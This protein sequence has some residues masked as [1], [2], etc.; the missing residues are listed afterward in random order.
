MKIAQIAKLIL[1]I[2]VIT[3]IACG[4]GDGNTLT[5]TRDGKI[6][7]IVKIGEQVWMA[8]NLNYA[9]EGSECYDKDQVNC[10]KYGRLYNWETAMKACPGGWHLPNAKEWKTLVDSAGGDKTAGKILKASKGWNDKGNG[11]DAFGFSALPGGY[12]GIG[13][14]YEGFF[15]AGEGGLWWSA[16]SNHY[17]NMRAI[18]EDAFYFKD[19]FGSLHSLR[20]IKGDEVPSEASGTEAAPAGPEMHKLV[21]TLEFKSEQIPITVF[22]SDHPAWPGNAKLD[23]LVF[24][25]KGIKQTVL[26]IGLDESFFF[27]PSYAP[28]SVNDYN[29]DGFMDIAILGADGRDWMSYRYFLYDPQK[30]NYYFSEELSSGD[31]IELDNKTQTIKLTYLGGMFEDP[32]NPSDNRYDE[33][34]SENGRLKLI[35]KVR[36]E[37]DHSLGKYIRRVWNSQTDEYEPTDTLN[38]EI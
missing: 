37:Y 17:W 16:E 10:E 38:V 26:P 6:Y 5:D 13:G 27:E 33:Y 21:G 3:L 35:R 2:M 32:D 8:E 12:Y 22:Y 30:Q 34:K 11:S 9:A 29:F 7:K 23:S 20:C 14:D 15:W 18:Y 1:A 25:Y 31:G 19:D 24:M 36:E 4:K 28:I